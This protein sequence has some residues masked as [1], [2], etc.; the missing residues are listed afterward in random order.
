MSIP[1]SELILNQDGSIYHLNLH[2]EDIAHTILTVGDPGRVPKV[3]RHFDEIELRKEKREFITHTG[4]IGRKRLTVISSGI[5]P[6]NIDIVLNELDALFNI[7]F[8]SRQPKRE[9]TVLNIIRIGT[10]GGLQPDVPVG[11]IVAARY[12]LGFDNLLHFYEYQPS[13][14]EAELFDALQNFLQYAGRLPVPPYITEGSRTLLEDIAGEM[15][16]GITITAPGFY[17]PQGRRLRLP[18]RL[19]STFLEKLANFEFQQVKITNFEMETAAIYGL[20]RL[21]GHRALSCNA[22]LV[23]RPRGSFSEDPKQLENKLIETVLTRISD[24]ELIS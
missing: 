17:G 22:L 14:A 21:L 1:A 8:E 24:S 23:N 16:Q 7:D 20:A 9:K 4:R 18:P 3:S 12:G 11:S 5:G 2:P 19:Q 13:M 6:D 15:F 10:S